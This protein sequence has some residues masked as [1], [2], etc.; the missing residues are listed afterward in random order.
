MKKLTAII[1]VL[2]VITGIVVI[3][4]TT[5]EAEKAPVEVSE[6]SKA[7]VEADIIPKGM[8]LKE[9]A[10]FLHEVAKTSL[11]LE[12]M[13]DHEQV[14]L[15]DALQDIADAPEH[16][17]FHDV[18]GYP[19]K[20]QMTILWAHLLSAAEHSARIRRLAQGK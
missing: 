17:D 10:R 8:T 7:P 9:E 18:M 15:V 3:V 2:L 4:N 13:T 20:R 14:W 19:S 12:P 11:A 1:V 16:L 6:V 5:E